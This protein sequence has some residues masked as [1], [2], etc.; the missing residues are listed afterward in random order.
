MFSSI[1]PLVDQLMVEISQYMSEIRI[2]QAAAGSYNKNNFKINI[3]YMNG[4]AFLEP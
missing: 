1:Y 4:P 2:A 3:I